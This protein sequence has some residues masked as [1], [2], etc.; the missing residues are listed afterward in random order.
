MN[1]RCSVTGKNFTVTDGEA[2][3]LESF[4]LPIPDRSPL[5]RWIYAI[6]QST[7][8]D[9]RRVT[10]PVTGQPILSRWSED[11][12]IIGASSEWFWSDACDNR[13]AGR[14]FDFSRPFFDQ[15][16]ELAGDCF[17]PSIN[18]VDCEGS[19]YVNACYHVKNCHLC[20][21]CR[22]IQDCLYCLLC[23][24]STDLL[25]CVGLSNSELCY[26]C[27][28]SDRLYGCRKVIDSQ[29][30][31]DCYWCRDCIGCT[32][33]FQCTGLRQA[34]DG[35]YYRNQRIDKEQWIRLVD[36]AAFGSFGAEQRID[37][38]ASQ[39]FASQ[40]A[41]TTNFNNENCHAS[42]RLT[43]S[44]NCSHT[45]S[46]NNCVDCSSL[47]FSDS[48]RDC[49]CVMWGKQSER[50]YYVAGGE[51]AY[52]C[53]FCDGLA[54]GGRNLT[55]CFC[56]Y[57][58]CTDLFGCFY[59]KKQSYCILNKQHSKDDYLKLRERIIEHMRE[60]GE[61]G[62]WFPPQFYA[63]PYSQSWAHY[64]L[65]QLSTEEILQRGL[66]APVAAPLRDVGA[67]FE[68]PD[69][70]GAF[71]DELCG[72]QLCCA[73]SGRPYG[74]SIAERDIFRKH[75]APIPRIHW[76]ELLSQIQQQ[77]ASRSAEALEVDG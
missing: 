61:W 33:C 6:G 72:K 59:L 49:H 73:L 19:P 60:T 35:Y 65:M 27:L 28:D 71:G 3:L 45:F 46:S 68:L 13:S 77:S 48:C 8:F 51:N 12:K 40:P 67:S 75:Q 29:G 66:L 10:C 18:Q 31:T 16:C 22:G 11:G 38:E 5:E 58:G 43:N 37:A 9:F 50:C 14:D 70:I 30:C 44:K 1:Y 69:Q 34:R 25:L 36:E 23:A 4:G 20:F 56:C 55:Y 76:G 47:R 42:F 2:R 52:D 74:V 17:A 54:G 21:A 26:A 53:A 64:F 41:Y 15:Y 32:N 63:V 39:F 62:R 24:Q 7:P 57:N